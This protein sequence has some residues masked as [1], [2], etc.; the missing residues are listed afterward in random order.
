M[1]SNCCLQASAG[2]KS[3]F[4]GSKDTRER[5]PATY[6]PKVGNRHLEL[7]FSAGFTFFLA[8][9]ARN[10]GKSIEE[11]LRKSWGGFPATQLLRHS[12]PANPDL[13]ERWYKQL[14]KL[15]GKPLPTAEEERQDP[16]RADEVYEA[17]T[18]LLIN[19]T[20]DL[21]IYPFI[22]RENVNYGF[23]R[24]LYPLRTLAIGIALLGLSVS[25]CAGFW[26]LRAGE[27]DYFAWACA[28]VCGALLLWWI[29]AVNSVWVKVPAMNY[30]VPF[31]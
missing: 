1:G 4:V 8:N 17:V 13:R 24:N 6:G 5:D 16:A 21:R 12:G 14:S 23:C 28:A 10:W 26:F 20:Q 27:I 15:L 9:V 25:I 18:R 2:Y 11:K 3:V 29:F 22:Y 19:K 30:A 7:L 31:V